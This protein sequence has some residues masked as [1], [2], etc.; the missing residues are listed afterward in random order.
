MIWGNIYFK[1]IYTLFFEEKKLF[2]S[3]KFAMF[4]GIDN[5]A[6]IPVIIYLETL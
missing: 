6:I 5:N 1:F 2:V 4:V 3:M